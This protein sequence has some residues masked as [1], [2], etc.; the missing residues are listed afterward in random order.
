MTRPAFVIA[1]ALVL[2][3]PA[4][5][6]AQGQ[7]S[8]RG[9]GNV[10]VTVFNATQ[11][12]KAIFGKPFGPVFGGGVEIGL[13]VHRLFVSLAAS[14]FHRTGH[15]VFVLNDQVFTFDVADTVTITPL[16]LTGGYRFRDNGL[17]PYAG[18]GIGWHR[19]EETSAQSL[20]GDDVKITKTGF[21]LLGG[22]ELP[23]RQWLS[24]AVDAQW[25]AVPNA[26]GEEITS[27]TNHYD[28]HDLGGFTLRA[29][30]IFGR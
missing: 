27:V 17:V 18:A 13:P 22:A 14:R 20:P 6:R 24:A 10:G 30:I 28:E 26:F 19:F 1:V 2:A 3:V 25:S 21:H 5:S 16:E 9:F 8:V 11:S 12:F 4:S 7:F 29:K 15:R 23:I